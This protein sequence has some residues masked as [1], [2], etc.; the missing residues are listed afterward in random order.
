MASHVAVDVPSAEERALLARLCL[1]ERGYIAVPGFGVERYADGCGYL[2][3]LGVG[4]TVLDVSHLGQA[5]GPMTSLTNFFVDRSGPRPV[6]LWRTL[7]SDD[8]DPPR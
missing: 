4:R 6:L 5:I 8:S 3:V 2:R 1:F 7:M